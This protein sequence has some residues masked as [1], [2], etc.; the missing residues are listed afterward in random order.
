MHISVYFHICI[1]YSDNFWS[2][3][4]VFTH[5][6][7]KNAQFQN[8]CAK[9]R[10]DFRQLKRSNFRVEKCKTEENLSKFLNNMTYNTVTSMRDCVMKF[11]LC[12]TWIVF[13]LIKCICYII[14]INHVWIR[15]KKIAFEKKNCFP[16]NP[17][18]S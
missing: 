10:N 9:K 14:K 5:I 8:M 15:V 4:C 1:C 3:F 6:S 12:K 17:L 2:A 7:G 16:K 18:F 13:I 11:F